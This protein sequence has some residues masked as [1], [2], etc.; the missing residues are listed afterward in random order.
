MSEPTVADLMTEPVLTVELD[1]RPA[2]VA[3]AMLDAQIKSVVV[4]ND[5]CHPVGILT[6]TDYVAL[7]AAGIDPYETTVEEQMTKDIVTVTDDEN[8]S[9]AAAL[10]RDHDIG[11][12]PVVSGD[13]TA[14]GIVSATDITEYLAEEN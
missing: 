10:M 11:H 8:F 13:G 2:N 7:T 5:D 4:I 6:S 1:E 14:I 3:M 12:V 9:E